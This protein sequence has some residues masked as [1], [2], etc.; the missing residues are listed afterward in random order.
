M[1]FVR[2][3][4]R[5]SLSPAVDSETVKSPAPRPQ[6]PGPAENENEPTTETRETIKSMLQNSPPPCILLRKVNEILTPQSVAA[7]YNQN[8]V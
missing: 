1:Q 3:F 4:W 6:N 5:L 7:A 2:E 8:G